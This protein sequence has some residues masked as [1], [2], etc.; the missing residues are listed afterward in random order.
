MGAEAPTSDLQAIMASIQALISTAASLHI[1]QTG[2]KP[3]GR[4]TRRRP[5]PA[6]PAPE[7][8]PC[9]QP[10]PVDAVQQTQAA[11]NTLAALGAA[12]V[13]DEGLRA[14]PVILTLLQEA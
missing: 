12:R 13:E 14:F 10:P 11:P 2:G 6:I 9:R 7:A 1:R 8:T 5:V 3:Q 4:A